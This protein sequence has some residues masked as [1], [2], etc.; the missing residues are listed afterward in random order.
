MKLTRFEDGWAQAALGAMFPGSRE[1]GF[2]DIGRMDVRGFLAEA[3][4]TLPFKAALGLRLAVWLVALAPVVVLHRFTT[5]RGLAPL[6]RER[7]LAALAASRTYAVRSLA[8]VLKTL[9]AMLYAGD[10]RIRA[11]LHFR[12]EAHHE[13]AIAGETSPVPIRAPEPLIALRVRRAPARVA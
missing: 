6:D 4:R 12:A 9:G 2:A 10:D 1:H 5:I 13:L 3:M 7:V 11:R 8:M